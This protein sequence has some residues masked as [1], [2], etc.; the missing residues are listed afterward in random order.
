MAATQQEEVLG[1]NFGTDAF[2]VRVGGRGEG[3]LLDLRRPAHPQPG[4]AAVLRHRR[5]V[6][7]LRPHV[8]PLRDAVRV[9]LDR[10]GASTATST[11]P[12]SRATRPARRG[13]R[14]R[15]PLRAA[16][17]ARPRLRRPDRR[18]PRRRAARL[19]GQLHRLV[20]RPA[21][22][23]D[24]AQLR[25]PRRLRLRRLVAARAGGAARG[26]DRHPRPPLEDPLDAQLRPVRVD[27]E[28]QRGDRGG[29]R[30]HRADGPPAVQ[31][32]GP[33]L[34]RDRGPVELQGGGQGRRRAAR[35][36]RGRHRGRRGRA[37][38]RAPTAAGASS[39]SAS[40]P[41]STTFGYK[42][43]WSHEFIYR[44]WAEDPAPIIEAIRGYV[45]T[46]YDY[47]ANLQSVRDDLEGAKRDVDGGR[48]GRGRATSSPARWRCR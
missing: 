45:A 22:P 16:H 17:A 4:V 21:A 32:R 3:A 47:P 31:R 37:R 34:G 14:V 36:V 8:P 39:P 20:A 6:A 33:Q 44:L 43:M 41:T 24:R 23:R 1:T 42:S 19:R 11:P 26:R 2:P 40:R 13:D 18:L 35:R 25:L 12:R 28:P 9:R 27:D 15:E 7:D 38:S 46:D 48:R 30:R 10:Q 5:L 29:R